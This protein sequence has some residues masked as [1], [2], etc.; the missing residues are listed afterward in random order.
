MIQPHLV[1]K[2][3]DKRC[4]NAKQFKYPTLA[5][6]IVDNYYNYVKDH[7]GEIYKNYGGWVWGWRKSC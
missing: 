6:T 7:N 2:E 5:A 1:N 3:L 4:A